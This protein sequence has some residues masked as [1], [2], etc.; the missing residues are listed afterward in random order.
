[1]LIEVGSVA[2]VAFVTMII[3]QMIKDIDV[4]KKIPTKLVAIVTAMLVNFGV[5]AIEGTV[6]TAGVVVY[7]IL[8]GFVVAYVSIYGWDTFHELKE[9]FMNGAK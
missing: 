7:T 9:R 8:S 2:G 4:L 5:L 3:V 1:M 6:L